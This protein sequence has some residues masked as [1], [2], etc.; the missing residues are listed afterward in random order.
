MNG[1]RMFELAQKLAVAKSRQDVPAALAVLHDDMLLET[2]PSA[3]AP[4]AL[5]KMRRC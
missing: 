1:N 2:L 4:A 3:P 5:P